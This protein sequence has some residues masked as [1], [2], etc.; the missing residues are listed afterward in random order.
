VL[1]VQ[2]QK[3][4]VLKPPSSYINHCSLTLEWTAVINMY[5]D[6]KK[7]SKFHPDRILVNFDRF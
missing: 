6:V 1:Y 5:F 4:G 3:L 7:N 2:T